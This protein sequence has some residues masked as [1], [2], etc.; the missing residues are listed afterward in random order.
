MKVELGVSQEARAGDDGLDGL[1]ALKV[2][3]KQE[4]V[5]RAQMV[6]KAKLKVNRMQE[7][8]MKFWMFPRVEAKV[9]PSP[10]RQCEIERL[11]EVVLWEV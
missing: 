3:G 6:Q 10:T 5:M 2:K 1:V 4:S 8:E 7:L 9:S 11:L